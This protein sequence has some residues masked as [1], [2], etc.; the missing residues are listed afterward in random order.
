MMVVTVVIDG[1][2]IDEI[3]I[4]NK[5][6][7]KTAPYFTRYEWRSTKHVASGEVL[8]HPERGAYR[9]AEHVL[10]ERRAR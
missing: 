4:E 9:L 7:V 3:Q 6:V 10:R 2:V 1:E 5:G 8:H